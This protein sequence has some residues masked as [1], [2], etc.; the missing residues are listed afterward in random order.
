VKSSKEQSESTKGPTNNNKNYN[1]TNN[2]KR[3]SSF[4]ILENNFE[5]FW[6]TYPSIK[7][8]NKESS[9]R[10]Y[11]ILITSDKE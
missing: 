11:Q 5:T 10:E 8:Q 4:D 9:K 1:K 3:E 7:K 6:N 2:T